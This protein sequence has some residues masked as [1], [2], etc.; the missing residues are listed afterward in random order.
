M[1]GICGIF[2]LNLEPLAHPDRITAMTNRLAHRGPDS[3][4]KIERPH[5][6]FGIRRLKIIDLETGDQPLSNESGDVSLIFNGEIYN[7]RELRADLVER[8]HRFRTHSD[9]EVI[10][11]LYEEKGTECLQDLNGMFAIALWDDHER[12]LLLAR[13]RAGEKPLYYW[14]QGQNFL[15]ASEIKSLFEYRE[16]P[17]QP[18]FEAW[19]QYLLHGYI[20]A[21]RTAFQGVQKL[22]AAHRMIIQDGRVTIEPYWRLADHLRPP[23]SRAVSRKQEASLV[24]ELRER[25]RQAAISRLV[26][27]VPLGVFLS[28]G[29]DSSTLV[30]LMSELAPGQVNSFS[31]SFDEP[32]F[33]E[34]PYSSLV[35]ARFRTLH[36]VLQANTRNLRE[37][38][39]VMT[40]YLDEPLADPAVLPTLLISRFARSEITVAL[41]GEGSDE[42]FGGY[43]TYL[44]ARAADFY[45]KLPEWLRQRI[46]EPLG[47][48][49][50]ASPGAVPMGL[51]LRRFLAHAEKAPAERHLTWFGMF[52]PA[53]IERL[54]SPHW[55]E[56]KPHET[57]VALGSRLVSGARFENTLAEVLYLDFKTYLEDNLLVKVDRASM[58][59]SL[60]MRTPFL[61]HRLME[62]A[63]GLPSSLKVRRFR[64]KHILKKAV[65]PWL[66]KEIVYR[67]KRGFSVPTS[68]WMRGELRPLLE[69]RLSPERLN[70][71]GWFQ[72]AFVR[73][74]LDEHW[75]GRADH[76][77]T[78]WT[79]LLFELW[80]DR[81]MS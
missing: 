22:P 61:D 80:Y 62:F 70:R 53:E 18:D 54:C 46:L 37:A 66:P 33:N 73:R 28:G 78:L 52:T 19:T 21:P 72:P 10:A 39:D 38:L 81:W 34:Q 30:A 5:L 60:E 31:V 29:V 20:P 51:F 32:T 45:L 40:E 43:P 17:R 13:D 14:Q 69:E 68:A 2:N 67:Q 42:L 36:H 76:R 79:L 71:Q 8:G 74:L 16:V 27:D 63:A 48:N 64:M 50:P 1:C 57:L 58:A 23:G 55:P 9:G 59:C 65:E 35:A 15:F 47:R 3:T 12:R 41:S 7:F 25:I 49:L 77:K 75:S 4:G 11:H 44:G 56:P 6:A 24:A 26:S